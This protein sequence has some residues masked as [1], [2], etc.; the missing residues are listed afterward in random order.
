MDAENKSLVSRVQQHETRESRVTINYR[1]RDVTMYY[2]SDQE[3][4]TIGTASNDFSLQL[5]FFGAA[6]GVAVTCVG[7]LSTV[8]I[9]N[10][11]IYAA[12]WA[13]LVVAIPA[14]VFFFIRAVLAYRKSRQQIRA[15]REESPNREPTS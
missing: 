3:L 9:S 6:L 10:P 11:R 14:T 12:Y 1:P 2:I 5:G 7:V 8:E 13:V 4:E 15:I